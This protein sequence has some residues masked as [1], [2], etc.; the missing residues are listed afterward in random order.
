MIRYR[1]FLRKQLGMMFFVSAAF[2]LVGAF[3]AWTHH[4]QAAADAALAQ[5]RE[6]PEYK[7]ASAAMERRNAGVTP[8]SSAPAVPSP[9]PSLD[10][11]YDAAAKDPGWKEFLAS[12][13]KPDRGADELARLQQFLEKHQALLSQI[14]A[15][16]AAGRPWYTLDLSDRA[17]LALKHLTPMRDFARLLRAD[18]AVSIQ[19]GAAGAA[20]EDLQAILQLGEILR[21]EPL[22]ISQMFRCAVEGIAVDALLACP[23]GSF[24]P[25]QVQELQA[26]LRSLQY[27]EPL[28][29]SLLYESA[30]GASFFDAA[31][32]GASLGHAL[33]EENSFSSFML[34]LYG[35][36][37]GRPLLALDEADYARG[38]QQYAL[39]AALPYYQ[40]KPQL[41]DIESRMG[42]LPAWR[43]LTPTLLPGANGISANVARAE[44]LRDVSYLGLGVEL[45]Q[46]EHGEYPADLSLIASRER[47]TDPFT[48][49][50]YVY[51]PGTGNF[52]LYSLGYNQQDDHGV[53]H[54][55]QGDI[56]WRGREVTP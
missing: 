24:A 45:Y 13:S 30:W 25:A 1:P 15:L 39:A 20:F 49:E 26:A 6:Q 11:A 2:L 7:Q 18:L 51:R 47:F 46:R 56:V 14:R 33:G 36:P 12:S 32:G 42:N 22:L 41:D 55:R 19:Q 4:N 50:P 5:L 9:G 8:P 48:G 28:R 10:L 38:M 3:I 23:P 52:L 31:R 27:R 29:E 53:H 35:G 43:L 16:A 37:L 21:D 34:D 54:F 44:A 40:A 17:H